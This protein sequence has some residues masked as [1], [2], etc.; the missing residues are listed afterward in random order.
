MS[1]LR[2]VG[3]VKV[4]V[5]RHG[6]RGHEL[7]QMDCFDW[8]RDRAASSI[9]AIV[10]DPPFGLIEYDDEQLRKR[11][12]GK[13]G[14][15]RIPPQLDG[16]QRKP[17][18]RFT[19]L[20][21]QELENL[22]SFFERWGR[23]VTRVLVPGGHVLIAGNPLLSP[24]VANALLSVGLERRGEIIRLVRTLRGGDRPK[25]AE[26]EYP[27]VSVMARSCYEPWGIF[28]KPL[29]ERTVADNLRKWG[30]GGLRRTPDGRPFP[31]VLKSETPPAT[32][33]AIAPHPS[34]KPQRFMRQVVWASLPLGE[35]LVVDPFMG[36]GSTIAAAVA[37]GYRAI[38]VEKQHEFFE[39]AKKAVPRLA[40]L[41]VHWE[42]FD[43]FNGNNGRNQPRA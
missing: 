27:G 35:G 30:T 5:A 3:Q 21:Q 43:A 19:V 15:W 14:V 6:T 36:S 38:G 7:V 34:L 28:R 29:G 17:L 18:P 33:E 22:E 31:D 39:M 32:E 40:V 23:E 9:H 24:C 2:L 26:R 41:D 20:R 37:V 16:V 4:P 10:T 8:L 11:E 25:L 42:P 1:R 12:L 13:G